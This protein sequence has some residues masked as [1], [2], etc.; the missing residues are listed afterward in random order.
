MDERLEYL[1]VCRE[2][3]YA[4]GAE[5]QRW[6]GRFE[7]REKGRFDL[8][9]QADLAAQVDHELPTAPV[10]AEFPT[11]PVVAAFPTRAGAVSRESS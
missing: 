3:V 7:V 1:N 5:L 11:A 8:V 2:A 4:A 9:T 10:V 6:V